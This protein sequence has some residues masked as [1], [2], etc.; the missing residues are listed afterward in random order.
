MS[1]QDLRWATADHTPDLLD[2]WITEQDRMDRML[3][4][5]GERLLA[6]ARIGSGERV[7]DIGCGTGAVTAHAAAHAMPGGTVVGID[8][9]AHMLAAAARRSADVPGVSL[10]LGDAQTHPF[11][12]GAHDVGISRFGMGHFGD[13]VA[14][15]RNLRVAL[16]PGG[17]LTF[18]EWG[19]PAANEWMTLADR[20]GAATLGGRWPA[21]PHL[22]G[23]DE[24]RLRAALGQAG[25]VEVSVATVTE[26]MWAGHTVPDVLAWF[27]TL[28]DSRPLRALSGPDRRAYLT[29]LR[30]ELTARQGAAGVLLGGSALLVRARTVG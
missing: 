4:P 10:V 13:L 20:V 19:D 25:F 5:Y 2:E 11:D 26:P 17:R 18:V 3:A 14:A 24:A 7:I 9:S 28:P 6:A 29:A 16:R 27:Q 15:L 1:S 22:T 30:A 12:A 8:L 23:G 21:R